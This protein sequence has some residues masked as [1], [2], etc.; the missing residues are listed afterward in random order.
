MTDAGFR[1]VV[2]QT[3]VN[4]VLRRL[5]FALAAHVEFRCVIHLASEFSDWICCCLSSATLG[6]VCLSFAIANSCEL[7][8]LWL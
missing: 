6:F 7:S 8:L 4:Y 1:Y 5:L 3:P 2:M